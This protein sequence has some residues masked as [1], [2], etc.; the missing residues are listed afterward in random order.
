MTQTALP[1]ARRL[2]EQLASRLALAL[3]L[4]YLGAVVP[5]VVRSTAEDGPLE[6]VHTLCTLTS[7]LISGLQQALVG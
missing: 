5:G 4:A 3:L 7:W 2:A 1:V 6:G